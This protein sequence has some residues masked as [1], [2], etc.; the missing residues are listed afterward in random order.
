MLIERCDFYKRSFRDRRSRLARMF[1]SKGSGEK[2]RKIL[3]RAFDKRENGAKLIGSPKKL[4]ET[5]DRRF[6]DADSEKTFYP[7][8]SGL[9]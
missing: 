6:A 5:V 1:F 4:G 8:R 2:N 3:K 7:E 9:V